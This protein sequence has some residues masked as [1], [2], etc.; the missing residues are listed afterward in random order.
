MES[1]YQPTQVTIAETRYW[2]L[3]RAENERNNL[4]MEVVKLKAQ[5]NALLNALVTAERIVVA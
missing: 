1:E 4:Q 5:I 2:E 3:Q